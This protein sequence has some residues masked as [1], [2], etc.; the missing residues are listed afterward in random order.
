MGL[1]EESSNESHLI[2]TR[3]TAMTML[4]DGT[5]TID[6]ANTS[7]EISVKK[8]GFLTVVGTLDLQSGSVEISDGSVTSVEVAASSASYTTG[9]AKRDEHIRSADFLDA[10]NHPTISFSASNAQATAAGYRLAGTAT[11]KGLSSPLVFDVENLD[12][13]STQATFSASGSV[14][15][16]VIGVDKLPSFVIA[17]DLELTIAA[18]ASG[19][20]SM[21]G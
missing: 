17:N 11:V 8:L 20:E 21:D 3:R 18:A 12:V 16:K 2:P 9:N 5:W 7:L 10:S 4:P 13:E 14:D 6:P 15:R 19:T 1:L